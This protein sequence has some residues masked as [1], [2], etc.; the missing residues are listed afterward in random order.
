MA[1]DFLKAYA[2]FSNAKF[3][4][5]M[6]FCYLESFLLFK[7]PQTRKKNKNKNKIRKPYTFNSKILYK[8]VL[9]VTI[10]RK[11]LFPMGKTYFPYLTNISSTYLLF[12]HVLVISWEV[13]S[14]LHLSPLL[15]H[16]CLG[17]LGNLG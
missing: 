12:L 13:E 15:Q 2:L 16:C 7:V 10:V 9:C 17:I 1:K 11:A 3:V 6:P 5:S 8:R 4:I 14:Y